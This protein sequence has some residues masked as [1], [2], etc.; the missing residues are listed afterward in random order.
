M[1]KPNEKY[2]GRIVDAFVPDVGDGKPCL[3]VTIETDQGKT[4]HRMY[5]SPAA[6]QYTERVLLELGLEQGHLISP[7]FWETPLRWMEGMPCSIETEEYEYFDKEENLKK[8]VRVKWLNGPNGPARREVQR[9]SPAKARGLASLF[10][11]PDY[12][13]PAAP[14]AG[15]DDDVPF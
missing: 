14:A 12:N 6:R 15:G 2:S 3:Q 1:L 8:G 10:A 4:D 9:A 7:D 11:R 5:L 13:A